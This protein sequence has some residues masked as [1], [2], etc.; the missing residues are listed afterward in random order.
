[1]RTLASKSEAL[2]CRVGDVCSW[3]THVAL[4]GV[5]TASGVTKCRLGS[6]SHH[7]ATHSLGVCPP[8]LQPRLTYTSIYEA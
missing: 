6:L 4:D 1:M 3:A 2:D 7:A 5:N 8:L